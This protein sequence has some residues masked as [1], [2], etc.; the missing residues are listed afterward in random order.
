[1]ALAVQHAVAAFDPFEVCQVSKSDFPVGFGLL[2]AVHSL[3]G[4]L[5]WFLHVL[6]L[7]SSVVAGCDSH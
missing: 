6:L 5:L 3:W 2:L 7:W 1:M 4:F